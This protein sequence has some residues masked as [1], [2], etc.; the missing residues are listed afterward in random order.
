MGKFD[1]DSLG[2][3]Q[4]AYEI[5]YKQMLV[6]K[7]PIVCRVDGH[8]F[9]SFTKNMAKPFD[10][11][12]MDTMQ[13]TML[14]LCKD[15]PTCKLGYTQ[16]DEITL[17]FVCDDVIR[18]EGLFKYKAQ[19]IMSLVASKT[20]RYFNKF[21]YENVLAYKNDTSVFQHAAD[22]KVYENKLFEAEFDCRVMNIPEWDVINNLIWRQQDATR[23]SIQMLGQAYFTQKELDKKNCSDI[24]DMLVKEKNIN[25]NDLSIAKKRGSCCYRKEKENKKRKVWEVDTQMPI[26][27]DSNARNK[28]IRIMFEN[29]TNNPLMVDLNKNG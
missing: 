20:T 6:P 22:I 15:L 10:D 11:L 1:K 16:S 24:M 27:T 26:L 28:F 9:H 17:V 14:A 12:L 2:E 25:W 19:K 4:K 13:K 23:N 8:A 7:A 21:F 18:T 5:V 3:R 29:I